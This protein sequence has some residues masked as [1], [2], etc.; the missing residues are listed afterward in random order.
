MVSLIDLNDFDL[1]DVENVLDRAIDIKKNVGDFSKSMVGKI[2]GSL[3]LEPSTRTQ[4]SFQAAM[5]RLGGQFLGFSDPQKSSFAKGESFRDTLKIMGI[6]SDLL[7]IRHRK[8]GAARAASMFAGCPVINAGDGVHLHPTQTLVDLLTIRQ[9]KGG[10]CGLTFGFCGDLK[11]G[12]PVN[13][14]VRMLCRYGNNRFV[15]VSTKEQQISKFL[16]GF[17]EE[18]KIGFVECGSLEEVISSLDVLYMTRVQRERFKNPVDYENQKGRFR[19]NKKVLGAAKSDLVV[20]HPLP[21]N[22][23]IDCEVDS[24]GRAAYFLQAEN[25]I[26]GRMALILQLFDEF[27]GRVDDCFGDAKI[28]NRVCLN[29]N[30]ITRFEVDLPQFFSEKNGYLNCSYCDESQVL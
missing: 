5:M 26:Y 30:C 23:E 24:D 14:L 11:F 16:R 7:V 22:D 29:E 13:S 8:D 25:G 12:R 28:F 27:K 15:F 2:M 4:F 9:L 19:L 10:C 1:V 18:R 21:R 20:L 6:Y 3:F 17:L